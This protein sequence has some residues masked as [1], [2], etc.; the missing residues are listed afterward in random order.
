MPKEE[1]EKALDK[2]DKAIQKVSGERIKFGASINRLEHAGANAVNMNEN[3]TS[4]FAKIEDGDIALQSIEFAK[5]KI[6]S[7]SNALMVAQANISPESIIKL[8]SM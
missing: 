7:Q 3:I 8:L 2:I 1:A 4:S 5:I 6:I